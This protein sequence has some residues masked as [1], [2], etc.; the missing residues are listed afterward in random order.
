[1][2]YKC[3]MTRGH[4]FT[5]DDLTRH[6]K[7]LWRGELVALASI[8]LHCDAPQFRAPKALARAHLV[9]PRSTMGIVQEGARPFIADPMMLTVHL[10]GVAFRREPVGGQHD[11]SDYLMLGDAALDELGLRSGGQ[12][13]IAAADYA[14]AQALFA[15]ARAGRLARQ[16]PLATEEAVLTLAARLARGAGQ[17][18]APASPK[19]TP[20]ERVHWDAVARAK[21]VLAQQGSERWTLADVAGRASVSPFHLTR[22]FRQRTGL[23]L[24]Q[25]AMALKARRCLLVIDRYAGRIERLASELGYTDAAHL[26]R[27]FRRAFGRSPREWLSARR[28]GA[29]CV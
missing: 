26:T 1:M 16:T 18:A 10:P 19:Q 9:L 21:R 11:L 29:G 20:S 6:D 15:A 23:G 24:H 27:H 3:A 22:L 13:A 17:R 14:D 4:D 28:S 2:L 12:C 5:V 8:G 25:Y 7:V